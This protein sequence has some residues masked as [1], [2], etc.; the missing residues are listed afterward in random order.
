M[1]NANAVSIAEL[2]A[3]VGALERESKENAKDHLDFRI[4]IEAIEKNHGVFQSDL[5]HIQGL[6]N[7][8]KADVKTL[9]ERP[10]KRYDAIANA[11]LQ[12][13]VLAVLAAVVVFK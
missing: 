12:W 7:E 9:K 6:C 4:R 11:V 13:L 2:A 8:I 3:R 10:V 5:K 1:E